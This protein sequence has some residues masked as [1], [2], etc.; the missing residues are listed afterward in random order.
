MP[1]TQKYKMRAFTDGFGAYYGAQPTELHWNGR[2]RNLSP[3]RSGQFQDE[4]QITRR[5][6]YE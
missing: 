4:N 3:L 2:R 6:T 1:G 5:G